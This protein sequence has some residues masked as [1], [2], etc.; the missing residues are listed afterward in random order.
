MLRFAVGHFVVR[1]FTVV[2]V[3]RVGRVGSVLSVVLK[4]LLEE[5][6]HEVTEGFFKYPL[7]Q[8]GMSAIADK[9]IFEK[10]AKQ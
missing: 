3:G 8:R 10:F 7:S 6:C 4:A 2:I 1:R 5:S 9:G